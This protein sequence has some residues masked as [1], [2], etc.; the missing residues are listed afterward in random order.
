[1]YCSGLQAKA[2]GSSSVSVFAILNL[3]SGNALQHL[4]VFALGIMPYISPPST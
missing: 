4:T 2:G 3:L 1:M